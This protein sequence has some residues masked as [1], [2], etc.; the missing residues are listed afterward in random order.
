MKR[1]QRGL[2][3]PPPASAIGS[4]GSK[5]EQKG[6]KRSEGGKGVSGWP[7]SV[8]ATNC[9]GEGEEEREQRE[10]KELKAFLY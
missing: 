5:G 3:S 9:R 6:G 10:G 7:P 4:N 1:E 2:T 8:V